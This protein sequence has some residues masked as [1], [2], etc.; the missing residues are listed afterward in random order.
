MLR[1]LSRPSTWI[2]CGIAVVYIL[3]Q[4]TCLSFHSALTQR[5]RGQW[6]I[7]LDAAAQ[8]Q[9]LDLRSNEYYGTHPAHVA[10]FALP[11]S[12]EEDQGG[13]VEPNGE[14]G[15]IVRPGIPSGHGLRRVLGDLETCAED[16]LPFVSNSNP[17]QPVAIAGSKLRSCREAIFS[18]IRWFDAQRKEI[19]APPENGPYSPNSLQDRPRDAETIYKGGSTIEKRASIVTAE[20]QICEVNICR[21]FELSNACSDARKMTAGKRKMCRMCNPRNEELIIKHCMKQ[22]QRQQNVLY[23]LIGILAT[24]S[25]AAIIFVFLRKAKGKGR[26]ELRI[27]PAFSSEQGGMLPGLLSTIQKSRGLAQMSDVE[28]NLGV[29]SNNKIYL[30][31]APSRGGPEKNLSIHECQ[32]HNN[33]EG[34]ISPLPHSDSLKLRGWAGRIRPNTPTAW[35]EK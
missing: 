13:N 18:L 7:S 33:Q 21:P 6:E 12:I 25:G 14:F 16:L 9:R 10:R 26:D 2:A 22:R 31:S 4:G 3:D 30:Q 19:H 1:S 5:Q 32:M 15:K 17:E 27:G 35:D 29:G 24:I 34:H 11:E 8:S 23:L 20:Y 28:R